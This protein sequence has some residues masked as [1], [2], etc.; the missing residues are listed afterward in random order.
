MGNS[1]ESLGAQLRLRRI[2]LGLSEN[3]VS[4]ASGI[5]TSYY[6]AIET[7][8]RTPPANTLDRIM[9]AL[10]ISGEAA[11]AV[12]ELAATERGLSLDDAELPE[13]VQGLIGDIRKAANTLQP[14]FTKW[15]R[16]KIREVSK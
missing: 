16:S 1:L 6:S 11:K 13:E 9:S 7:G 10:G 3:A 12:R 15:L 8:R 2:E 14:R 4:E 5:S